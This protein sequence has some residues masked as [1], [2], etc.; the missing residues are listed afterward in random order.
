MTRSKKISQLDTNGV[1]HGTDVFPVSSADGASTYKVSMNDLSQ[2]LD[3]NSD[4]LYVK[5]KEFKGEIVNHAQELNT[6]VFLLNAVDNNITVSLAN[7]GLN[8]N[9]VFIFKRLDNS[10]YTVK[11]Q[12]S[13]GN[14]I[15]GQEEFIIVEQF[16][17]VTIVSHESETITGWYIL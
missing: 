7:A 1:I 16:Q 17:S 8:S 5:V 4:F 14:T 2:Y 15:D 12:G 3:E 11:L 9:K 10:Q 6:Y 13:P